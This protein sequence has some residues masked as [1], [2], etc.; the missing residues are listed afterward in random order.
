MT[1]PNKDATVRGT[2]ASRFDVNGVAGRQ[3]KGGQETVSRL[4]LVG[5]CGETASVKSVEEKKSPSRSTDRTT[6]DG[7][8]NHCSA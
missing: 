7:P 8:C 6:D 4:T 3:A 5:K 1:P 2:G